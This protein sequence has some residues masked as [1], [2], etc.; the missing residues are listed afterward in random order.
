LANGVFKALAEGR[1]AR[2]ERNLFHLYTTVRAFHPIHLDVYGGPELTPRQ[3]PYRSLIA[4]IG[5]GKLAAA[6]RTFQLPVA[7]LPPNPQL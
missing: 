3:V 1:L 4:V 5:T 2:Q 6:A 7:A